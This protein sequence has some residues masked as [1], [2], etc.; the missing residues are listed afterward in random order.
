MDTESMKIR[1][2]QQQSNLPPQ[3]DF[4]KKSVGFATPWPPEQSGIAYH[5]YHLVAA[6][7]KHCELTLLLSSKKSSVDVNGKRLPAY[8]IQDLPK[9]KDKFDV[10]IYHVGCSHFHKEIYKQAYHIPGI[11]VLHDYDLHDFLRNSYRHKHEKYLYDEACQFVE[12]KY[13][14][15]DLDGRVIG[16][17]PHCEALVNRSTLT[18]V[19]NKWASRQL[20]DFAQQV[21]VLPLAAM[22]HDDLLSVAETAHFKKTLGIKENECVIGIFGFVHPRK[23]TLSVLTAVSALVRQGYPV[24]L[25]IAGGVGGPNIDLPALLEKFNIKD[26]T[27][28]TDFIEDEALF[29]KYMW[30][31]DVVINLRNPTVGEN[32]GSLLMALGM[33]KSCIVSDHKQYQEFPDH[34]CWK[35]SVMSTEIAELTA[36]LEIVVTQPAV[37]AQLGENARQYIQE[38]CAY[39]IVARQY[40]SLI[41]KLSD[42]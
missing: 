18:I 6:L 15:H 38:D 12:A 22:P 7:S 41:D 20:Q 30:A 31:T 35:V 19:H 17:S 27:I 23:R 25:L 3:I 37:R 9:I 40:A 5:N 34:V 11:V 1:A 36:L 26:K 24:K 4:R 16:E 29:K 33:G 8:P 32:S 14:Q 13:D 39:D 10:L 28:F 42:K 21:E 2:P